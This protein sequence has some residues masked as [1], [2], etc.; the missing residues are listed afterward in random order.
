MAA[1]ATGGRPR[2]SSGWGC[3]SGGPRGMAGARP[4]RA[5]VAW[6]ERRGGSGGRGHGL[7]GLR[8]R[9]AVWAGRSVAAWAGRRDR[10][11]VV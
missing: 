11:S 2:P 6:L 1:G 10:K 7:V 3:S 5:G 4:G 8:G 9:S